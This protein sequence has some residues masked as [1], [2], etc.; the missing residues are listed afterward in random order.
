MYLF[1]IIY[2]HKSKKFINKWKEHTFYNKT[3]KFYEILSY[4]GFG[5]P[6]LISQ[7]IARF[8]PK[9]SSKVIVK[10]LNIFNLPF[11][12]NTEDAKFT[13]KIT[14]I[15][16]H[17]HLVYVHAAFLVRKL[18]K[19]ARVTTYSLVTTPSKWIPFSIKN[20][21]SITEKEYSF[22]SS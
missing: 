16:F 14:I 7:R 15:S 3:P 22:L 5:D 21:C 20:I 18:M 4:L 1:E 8:C 19:M 12:Q 2:E 11:K 10:I 9:S 17:M 13:R 6:C